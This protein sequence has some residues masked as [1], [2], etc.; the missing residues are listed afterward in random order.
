MLRYQQLAYERFTCG[1]TLIS[2][3]DIGLLGVSDEKSARNYTGNN[4]GSIEQLNGQWYVFYHR[5]TNQHHFSRQECAEQIQILPDSR[6]PQVEV[7]SQGLNGKPLRGIGTYDARMACNLFSKNGAMMYELIALHN[8]LA[9]HPYFTQDGAN[10]EDQPNQY[11][12]NMQDGATVGFKYFDFKDANTL[13]ITTQGSGQGKMLVKDGSNGTV[14]ATI[15]VQPGDGLATTHAPL[16]ITPGKHA[17]Y[18]LLSRAR[19]RSIF[20]VLS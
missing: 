9:H 15:P 10:R 7:T 17:P 5:Q 8:K 18:F 19:A 4:H 12:A 6:I 13:A 16:T 1:S 11:I 14:V 20:C 2:N 3:G